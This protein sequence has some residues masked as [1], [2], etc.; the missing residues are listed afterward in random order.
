MMAVFCNF[1]V[2]IPSRSSVEPLDSL[3]TGQ[4]QP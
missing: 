2:L 4:I 3:T 1:P